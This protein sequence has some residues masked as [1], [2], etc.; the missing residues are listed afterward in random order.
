VTRAV[1]HARAAGPAVVAGPFNLKS[2]Q[3]NL[4]ASDMTRME[5]TRLS[6]AVTVE[7]RAGHRLQHSLS[8]RRGPA[9]AETPPVRGRVKSESR[10]MLGLVTPSWTRSCHV[11]IDSVTRLGRSLAR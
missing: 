10:F 11:R 8:S 6:L 5:S 9:A 2:C 1:L 4:D 7:P 3:A